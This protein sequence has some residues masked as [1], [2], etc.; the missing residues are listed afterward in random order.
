MR[1]IYPDARLETPAGPVNAPKCAALSAAA[2][3][4]VHFGGG[5]T[6]GATCGCWLC[7]ADRMGEFIDQMGQE[8]PLDD[9]FGF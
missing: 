3:H 4:A 1:V 5:G 9:G 8:L 7:Y 2:R 6:H